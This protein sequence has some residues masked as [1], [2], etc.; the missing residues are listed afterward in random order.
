M[1]DIVSI[2][3]RDAANTFKRIYSIYQRNR[4]LISV[5]AYEPGSDPNI[6]LAIQAMPE[7]ER[8]LQQSLE[9][10]VQLDD[11]ILDLMNLFD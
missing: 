7:L 5:G 3:H 6:D 8:F 2:D 10:A 4:D 1:T 11:S 9:D